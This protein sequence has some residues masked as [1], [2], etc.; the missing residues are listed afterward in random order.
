MNKRISERD[1][2][3]A[4]RTVKNGVTIV[5][6]LEQDDDLCDGLVSTV[7]R[8]D[9]EGVALPR[10]A[11]QGRRQAH[12]ARE[13]VNAGQKEK[14]VTL[15]L[16]FKKQKGKECR[17]LLELRYNKSHKLSQGYHDRFVKRYRKDLNL[18]FVLYMLYCIHVMFYKTLLNKLSSLLQNL[19]FD[20]KSCENVIIQ[21]K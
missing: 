9:E 2:K 14:I 13:L 3:S 20:G 17:V 7:G 18:K 15:S 19:T 1:F 12:H 11:V 16:F 4:H 21:L 8:G 5:L 10:L 6:V